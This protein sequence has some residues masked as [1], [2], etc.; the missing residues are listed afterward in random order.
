MKFDIIYHKNNFLMEDCSLILAAEPG[1][2]FIYECAGTKFLSIM[3]RYTLW[4]EGSLGYVGI[5]VLSI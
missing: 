2:L 3:K 4:F 5:V 1:N